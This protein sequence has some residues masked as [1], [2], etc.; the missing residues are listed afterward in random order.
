MSKRTDKEFLSDILE[1]VHRSRSY[2]AGMPCEVFL[3][4]IETQDAVVRNLEVI[5][6]A[7]KNLSAEI[8]GEHSTVPWQS[9]AGV[10]DRLIRRYFGISLDVVWEIVNSE[11]D[12]V[13][14][15]VEQIVGAGIETGGA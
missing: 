3:E 12:T 8:R 4:D 6:E 2:T 5:G 14:S 7:A 1:A 15:Q 9:M 10:R 11:L 13:A